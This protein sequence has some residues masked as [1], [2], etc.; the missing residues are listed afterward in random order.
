MI[1]VMPS[2]AVSSHKEGSLTL[3]LDIGH[4]S[5]GWAVLKKEVQEGTP[6]VLG[7]GTVIFRGGDC[8]NSQRA[9]LR[10]SRRNI[11]ATRSRIRRME[12]ALA[13][14]GVLPQEQFD[15]LHAA[16]KGDPAPWWVM[17]RWLTGVIP[18]LSPGEFWQI[19]RWYAHHRGYDAN[20]RW[21]KEDGEE[22]SKRTEETRKEMAKAGANTVAEFLCLK[23]GCKP[24][25]RQ[26][27]FGKAFRGS[28]D[29]VLFARST[30]EAEVRKMVDAH[31][32]KIKGLDAN[33]RNTLVGEADGSW[34]STAWFGDKRLPKRYRGSL[35]F[36]QLIPRFDNRIISACPF[37]PEPNNKE[38]GRKVPSKA[39]WEFLNFRWAMTAANI[40]IRVAG[41]ERALTSDEMKK[42][43]QA[44]WD[45]GDIK[46]ATGKDSKIQ[47]NSDKLRAILKKAGL[48]FSSGDNLD[49][50]VVLPDSLKAFRLVPIGSGLKAFRAIWACA[51]DFQRRWLRNRLLKGD[52]L[53]AADIFAKP[54]PI[55]VEWKRNAATQ[56]LFQGKD[57]VLLNESFK[58][59]VPDGRA[60]YSRPILIKAFE[61]V[62]NGK[63]PREMKG[64]LFRQGETALEAAVPLDRRTNNHLVRHR[65][66]IAEKLRKD[67]VKEYAGGQAKAFGQVVIEINRDLPSLSGKNAKEVA[68]AE[69]A[70]LKN[71]NDVKKQLESSLA[72]HKVHMTAG[73]LRKARIASDLDWT[74][75]FTGQKYSAVELVRGVYDKDHIVP[76]SSRVSDSL[77]SL[78]VTKREVNKFKGNRTG[79]QFVKEEGGKKIPGTS[80]SV[81]SEDRYRSFVEN[82]QPPTRMKDDVRRSDIRK[83]LMLTAHAPKVDDVGFLPKDLTQTSYLAKL[84]L[85][86]LRKGFAADGAKV[87]VRPLP[88]LVTATARKTWKLLGC[89]VPAC[90]EA[91]DAAGSN[92]KQA[93]RKLTHLHHALDAV[94]LG[95][96]GLLL[97]REGNVLAALAA[98]NQDEPSRRL[99]KSKM[100]EMIVIS[101]DR[102]QLADLPKVLKDSIGAK[103]AEGRVAQHIPGTWS[104]TKSGPTMW[105]VVEKNEG[106]VTIRQRNKGMSSTSKTDNKGEWKSL[107][108]PLESVIESSS[109]SGVLRI[110]ENYGVLLSNPP[111]ILPWNCVYRRLRKSKG[112]RV[113]RKGN[114]LNIPKGRYAGIW[115]VAGLTLNTK[116]GILLN[117]RKPPATDESYENVSLK[118]LQNNSMEILSSKLTGC[119]ITL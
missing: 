10:R 83:R 44:C 63:D 70:K 59:E 5:I 78:V 86:E 17:A 52:E 27:A 2:Q 118:T 38:V 21:I 19:L 3:G 8:L 97:P 110:E 34:G 81:V 105:G 77:S 22:D 115:C 24:S 72:G 32:G 54:Q 92:D 109:L 113:F 18:S 68:S 64:C 119:P 56:T 41:M 91:K 47:K 84:A 96:S 98:R 79:L 62:M 65:I 11:R 26:P 80:L 55:F 117:L 12:K 28:K 31:I 61:E 69:S 102:A 48:D 95:L 40:R 9:S 39:N 58:G 112:L 36:G 6:E 15:R 93:I 75:P 66:R 89:L 53:T 71:F 74:C 103:L 25:D 94:V 76:R 87:D 104:G 4:R 20:R 33:L 46:P 114:L 60:A 50:L 100:G 57:S 29:S 116:S 85:Q 30:V 99:L 13:H 7:C 14:S 67:I 49:Q 43:F 82:L 88:G 107:V 111:E 42:F 101:E 51:N 73:L 1:K 16:G 37:E 23:S 35:L 108:V 45:E 106:R 90:P